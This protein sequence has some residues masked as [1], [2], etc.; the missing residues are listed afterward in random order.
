MKTAN[1]ICLNDSIADQETKMTT[2]VC[3]SQVQY[4]VT[5]VYLQASDEVRSSLQPVA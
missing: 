2:Y 1:Q 5:T 4:G 3:V